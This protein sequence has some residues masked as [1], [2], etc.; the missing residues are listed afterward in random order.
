M[1]FN[2]ARC[3]TLIAL[4]VAS[5]HWLR[6]PLL[7]KVQGLREFGIRT[8]KSTTMGVGKVCF[9]GLVATR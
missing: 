9:T 4:T 3:T 2:F 5:F 7:R 1:Q 6:Q 8:L